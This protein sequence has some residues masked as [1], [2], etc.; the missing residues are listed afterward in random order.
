MAPGEPIDITF[1]GFAAGKKNRKAP[2]RGGRGL[3]LEP[4]TKLALQRME[5]QVPSWARDRKLESPDVDWHMTYTNARV[6]FDGVMAGVLDI[7]QKYGV[8]VNDNVAHF[9]GKQ[10]IWP[11]QRGET[12]SIRVVL[13]PRET[14]DCPAGPKSASP[15]PL[16]GI[17][18]SQS[19]SP[20]CDW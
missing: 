11:P 5:L 10:I 18:R 3:Y 7:L 2:R 12:D 1:L 16:S 14:T 19:R 8:I 4:K 15:A 13:T 17:R 6:D 20:A 9:A